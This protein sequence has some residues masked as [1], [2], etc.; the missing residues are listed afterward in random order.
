M[1]KSLFSSGVFWTLVITIIITSIII[2]V[3]PF[4]FEAYKDWTYRLLIAFSFFFIMVILVLLYVIFLQERTQKKLKEYRERRR[5]ER[6]KKRVVNE[7]IKDIKTKFYEALKILKVST[8]YKYKRRARYE[9]PWYLLVGKE[10][11]GKTTL[12]EASGLDFPLNINYD[13]RS[14]KEEG[15]SKGFL[16]YYAE[17]AIFIDMPGQYINQSLSE[18]DSIVWEKGFLKIFAKKRLHRPLNGIILNISVDTFIQKSEKEL[19]QYAKDLRDRFDELSDGFVSSIPIYLIITKSDNIVGY[20]EYFAS[21]SEEEKEEVLG[22]SFDDPTMNI[23]TTVVRPELEKLLKRINS[24]VIDK[25]HH[26][27]DEETRTKIFLFPDEFS[28]IFEKIGMFTDICFAQTR[29]RKAL[30][31]RGIY[32]TSVAEEQESQTSYLLSNKDENKLSTGRSSRGNFI[33]KLLEEFIFSESDLIKMDDN[34]KKTNKRRQTIA[35]LTA[36]IVVVILSSLWI[37]NFIS[38]NNLLHDLEDRM[39]KVAVQKNKIKASDNF[40]KVLPILNEI[41]SIKSTYENKISD[42]F[43][44]LTFYDV[45]PQTVELYNL[46]QNALAT[47]L[48]PR[49]AKNLRNQILGNLYNYKRTWNNTEIYLMLHDEKH[50]KDSYIE[51]TMAKNWSKLYPNKPMVQ[52]A[53][54][55]HL[56]NLLSLGF[57]PYSLDKKTLKKARVVLHNKANVVI[58]YDELQRMVKQRLN[59]QPFSFGQGL[60]ANANVFRGANYEISGLYTKKGFESVIVTKGQDY[61]VE[62]LKNNWVLGTRTDLTQSEL[63]DVYAQVLSLYFKDYKTY[64]LRAITNLNVPEVR[65]ESGLRNQLEVL[66]LASS[67][68]ITVLQAVKENTDIYT[69]A[70]LILKKDQA[71]DSLLAKVAKLAAK[72]TLKRSKLVANI[73]TVRIFFKAYHDLLKENGTP[74]ANLENANLVLNKVFGQMNEV[75]SSVNPP[76]NAFKIVSGRV[77]GQV[78]PIVQQFTTLPLNVNRWYRQVLNYNW[79]YLVGQGKAHIKA[80]YEEEVGAFYEQRIQNRYPFNKSASAQSVSL[81]D[82]KFFFQSDGVLDS[83]FKKYLEPFVTVNKAMYRTYRS[84]SIDGYY[85]DFNMKFMSHILEAIR[86][87]HMFFSD[88]GTKLST[89]FSLAPKRLDKAFATM[90]FNNAQYKMTYEHGAVRNMQLEWPMQNTAMMQEATFRLYDITG[91][92]VTD[93]TTKGDWAFF[94]LMDKLNIRLMRNSSLEVYYQK[95]ND[96]ASIKIQ[97]EISHLRGSD[98]LFDNFKLDGDI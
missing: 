32:F 27:W 30:M 67:P 42:S 12:L 19:A 76:E 55:E 81:E 88:S 83:F 18:T 57:N 71:E 35:L 34:F 89:S 84:K 74:T 78:E 39:T 56:K 50:R 69:P 24:S 1:I 28:S 26:E 4:F 21:L 13:H 23:D 60:G 80:R 14:V 41:D 61:I 38:H 53:L 10:Q 79:K 8:L 33:K 16:W 46:Y 54:N 47:I 65:S 72:N 6:E 11:E 52:K 40:E 87:R 45:E 29:Y 51:M 91:K 49:V 2:F 98:K 44:K 90:E 82:F 77:N 73:K 97:G 63:D 85:M 20:N 94:R 58:L 93:I 31:L 59:L 9:L 62:I 92:K 17:H 3:F 15:P 37:N 5:I 70:E 25:L 96:V 68:I 7:K 75:F 95:A 22:I 66:S 86:I 48:L 43:Y 64:W 36:V